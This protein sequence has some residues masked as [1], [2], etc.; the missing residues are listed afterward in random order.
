MVDMETQ[1]RWD[2]RYRDSS[3]PLPA[4]R[5]LA[6][7]AHLLPR[8]GVAL[9]L[10][11]GLGGNALLLAR[12]GLTTYAWDISAVAIEKLQALARAENLPVIAET[13]DVLERPVEAQR[14]DVIV[15]TRFLERRLTQALFDALRPGGLL[16]YQTFTRL[17]MSD[18]GPGKDEWRLADGELLT[19]F[20]P[21]VP[22]VYREERLL[23]ELS[24][25]LR[26][27]ALLV[28]R[29]PVQ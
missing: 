26:N 11:C 6:E 29:K 5:V 23:G 9:D 7:N 24:A 25:G 20:A 28:A 3:V 22:V 21:L 18:E 1:R 4:V 27:E 17:R 19:M 2:E 12:C 16:Y 13:R 15:C 10:A 8:T 14:F